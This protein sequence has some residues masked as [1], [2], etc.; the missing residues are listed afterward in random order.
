[1]ADVDME[2]VAGGSRAYIPFSPLERTNRRRSI[3]NGKVRA[4][5]SR[6]INYPES[7]GELEIRYY[8][9]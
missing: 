4:C 5:D 7:Q 8:K 9:V 3:A 1:M 2:G 6:I